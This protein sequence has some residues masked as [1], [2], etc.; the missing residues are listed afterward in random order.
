MKDIIVVAIVFAVPIT[1]IVS[2]A[3]IK[4]RRLELEAGVGGGKAL[5]DRL[6]RLE[7][8]R[9]DL[10]ERVDALESIVTM[11]APVQPRTRVRVEAAQAA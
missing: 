8:E 1:A 10:Q 7:R 9:A 6:M 3:K 5:E 4:L 2:W 11:D